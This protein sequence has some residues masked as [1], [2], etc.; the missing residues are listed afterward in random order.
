MIQTPYIYIMWCV[1]TLGRYNWSVAHPFLQPNVPL[2]SGFR[3]RFLVFR[4]GKDTRSWSIS[5]KALPEWY[6]PLKDISCD[7][8]KH[9]EDIIEVSLILFYSQTY[10]CVAVSELDFWRS[11]VGKILILGVSV[12]R[13]F[14]ND[15]NSF[16]Y[17]MWCV[18]TLGRHN[19]SGA[20]LYLQPN[21]PL[22]S[23]V[24]T[25]SLKFNFS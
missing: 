10:L 19:W 14:H 7:V 17:P 15:T 2:C 1:Q 3:A 24:R 18:R 4:D 8:C 21:V 9:L 22:C 5:I 12:P 16:T 25:C 6:K 20:H 13:H 11:G 23:R